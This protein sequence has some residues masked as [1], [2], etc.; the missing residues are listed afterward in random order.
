MRLQVLQMVRSNPSEVPN[1][2]YL[3]SVLEV[4]G[5]RSRAGAPSCCPWSL[6]LVLIRTHEN[7]QRCLYMKNRAWSRGPRHVIVNHNN[8]IRFCEMTAVVI[9]SRPNGRSCEV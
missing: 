1:N 6:S 5:L 4:V 8:I 7:I 9:N 3:R 2:L